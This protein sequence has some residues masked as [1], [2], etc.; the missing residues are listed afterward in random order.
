MTT[1]YKAEYEIHY[2][3]I[4]F[5]MGM[6]SHKKRIIKASNQT[7]AKKKALTTVRAYNKNHK[8]ARMQLVRI[9]A[10]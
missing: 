2:P 1:R 3:Q 10:V 8:R 9:R 7:E 4:E 6:P 5:G